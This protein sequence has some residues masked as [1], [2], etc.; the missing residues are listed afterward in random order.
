M[1]DPVFLEI[2]SSADELH[3]VAAAGNMA[4]MFP[5]L[6]YFPNRVVRVI[7]TTLAQFLAYLDER[8][9]EHRAEFDPGKIID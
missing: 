2:S 6:E 8:L 5:I 4:D 3:R 1:D 7:K 9:K